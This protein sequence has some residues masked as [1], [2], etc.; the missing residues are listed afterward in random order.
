[1]NVELYCNYLLTHM[2]NAHYTSGKTQINCRCPECGDSKNTRS[3]HMYISVPNEEQQIPSLYYCHKCPAKG[4]M[5]YKKFIDWNIYDSEIVMD[6]E[7]YHRSISQNRN[8]LKYFHNMTYNIIQ[9]FTTMDEK[10]YKKLEYFNSRIGTNLSFEDLRKL[11]VV[12]NL[13]DLFT[14]NNITEF[15]REPFIINDL[16]REFI[17]FLSIDNAF[18]N[19]RRT[20]GEGL[21]YKSIDKRYINY[22]LFDKFD[23]SNKF[24]TI[25]TVINLNTPDRIKIHV[26]EGPFDIL[27]IYFNCR[28]MEP[29]IYTSVTGNNYASTIMY[30]LRDLYIP[31]SEL[32]FY[33]DNDKFGTD[34]RLKEMM[35][36]IPD[37]TIPVYVHRNTMIGE[38][39]FGVTPDKI[40]EIITK[41]KY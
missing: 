5:T 16:D 26:A 8:N 6:L 31:N 18:I 29:G 19:M 25:P 20:C 21:V 9:S 27:S 34:N 40:S 36:Y 12:V 28:K 1:M 17:G 7:A 4:I 37:K 11:K 39:D 35:Y 30:F 15:T 3:A 24:Y 14:N 38:K 23:N 41:L 10:S 2:K 22:T 13:R 32:H 33:P